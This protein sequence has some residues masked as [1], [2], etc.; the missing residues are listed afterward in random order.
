M[1]SRGIHATV[2]YFNRKISGHRICRLLYTL[3]RN[4][5][6]SMISNT[7]L[8]YIICILLLACVY[9]YIL[10]LQRLHGPL[11]VWSRSLGVEH[12]E[13]LSDEVLSI[14][15]LDL[16][17]FC[18]LPDGPNTWDPDSNCRTIAETSNGIEVACEAPN[19]CSFSISPKGEYMEIYVSYK[20]KSAKAKA[21]SVTYKICPNGVIIYSLE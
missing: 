11:I 12:P 13:K 20:I 18:P 21:T 16:I 4:F 1:M 14:C 5:I 19:V 7:A 3:T 6:F 8:V 2:N 17:S 15:K 10:D 9:F